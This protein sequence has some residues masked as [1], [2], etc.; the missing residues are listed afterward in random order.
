[1]YMLN[2][3]RLVNHNFRSNSWF[4]IYF[5][6]HS[7]EHSVTLSRV[8]WHHGLHGLRSYFRSTLFRST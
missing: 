6:K 1:M 2:L 4:V 8:V 5:V 7:C 3:C